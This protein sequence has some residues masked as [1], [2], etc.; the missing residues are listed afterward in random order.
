MIHHDR[1]FL[2]HPTTSDGCRYECIFTNTTQHL[3][4]DDVAMF[5]TR[6]SE[7]VRI[8]LRQHSVLIAFKTMESPA[9]APIPF[10][11]NLTR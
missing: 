11:H 9:Y 4:R 3:T 1:R 6:F 5:S 8:D 10:L 7:G 2:Y